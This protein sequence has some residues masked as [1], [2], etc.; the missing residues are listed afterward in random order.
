MEL[1]PMTSYLIVWMSCSRMDVKLA[2]LRLEII[3]VP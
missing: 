2:P 3:S 1:S